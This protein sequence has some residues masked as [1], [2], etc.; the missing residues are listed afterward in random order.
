MPAQDLPVTDQERRLLID[1]ARKWLGS[2]AADPSDGVGHGGLADED[3]GLG[4]PGGQGHAGVGRDGGGSSS[5]PDGPG[6]ARMLA[7]RILAILGER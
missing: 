5:R 4:G 3:P 2:P 6:Q 7:E 1:E